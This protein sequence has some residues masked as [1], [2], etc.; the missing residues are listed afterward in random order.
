[1]AVRT[2]SESQGWVYVSAEN[3]KK[4]MENGEIENG[5][6]LIWEQGITIFEYNRSL[7]THLSTKHK[8]TGERLAPG[9]SSVEGETI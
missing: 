1:M 9:A 6:L 3:G 8:K 7:I 5:V 4:L 2:D